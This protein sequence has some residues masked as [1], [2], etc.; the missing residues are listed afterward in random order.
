VCVWEDATDAMAF[1]L[2]LGGSQQVVEAIKSPPAV[3]SND[4]DQDWDQTPRAACDGRVST[5]LCFRFG[6]CSRS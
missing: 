2:F 1:F 4:Q 3:H 5:G 6:L